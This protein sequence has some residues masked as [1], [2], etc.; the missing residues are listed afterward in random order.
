MGLNVAVSTPKGMVDIFSLVTQG[1]YN[2]FTWL[3]TVII[4]V[5]FWIVF[6]WSF[7]VMGRRIFSFRGRG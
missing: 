5:V 1:V 2:F 4:R 6:L 7:E 3:V